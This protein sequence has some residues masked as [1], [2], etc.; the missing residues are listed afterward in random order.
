M[1]F[2]ILRPNSFRA[3]AKRRFRALPPSTSTFWK[4]HFLDGCIEDE[5]ETPCVGDVRPLVG[6]AEGDGDL[7]PWAIA[8]VGGGVFR[9]DGEHPSGDELSFSSAL[10]GGEAPKMVA[11]T[12]S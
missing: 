1:R 12:L 8:G 2:V 7:G 3:L 10:G 9:S 4:K 6:P 11:T 5:E